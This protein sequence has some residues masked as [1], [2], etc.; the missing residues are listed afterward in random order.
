MDMWMQTQVLPPGMKNTD[1]SALHC[2]MAIAERAQCVPHSSKQVIV[3]PFAI[4]HAYAMKCLRNGEHHMIMV[5]RISMT[6]S[7]FDPERLVGSLALG[8]V[9]IATA[10]ITDLIPAAMITPILM[11][12][13]S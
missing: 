2:V 8:T 6:H 1:G 11:P 5:D 10:I 4:Q 9:A 3:K 13:K 12:S 7:I